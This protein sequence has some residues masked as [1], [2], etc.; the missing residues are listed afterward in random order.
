VGDVLHSW[1]D[2]SAAGRDLGYAPSISV[3]EGL[4]RTVAWYRDQ[5]AATKSNQQRETCGAR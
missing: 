2:I 3:E 4:R 5:H 1:S